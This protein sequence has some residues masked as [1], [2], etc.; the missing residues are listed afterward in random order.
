MSLFNIFQL[1]YRPRHSVKSSAVAM[2]DICLYWAS[3]LSDQV[4]PNTHGFRLEKL[5]CDLRKECP[6]GKTV[7]R[8]GCVMASQNQRG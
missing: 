2:Q 4:L 8:N 1:V 6:A 5:A 3:R 7:T